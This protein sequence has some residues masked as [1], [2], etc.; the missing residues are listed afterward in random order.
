M[1]NQIVKIGPVEF[2]TE[3]AKKLYESGKCYI[4]TYTKIYTINY[5]ETK[6]KFYGKQFFQTK[7]GE[8]FTR[9]GR[10]YAMNKDDATE[11]LS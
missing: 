8:N 11:L 4:I 6:S 10:F 1:K 2:T 7:N 9:R 3:E 5:D